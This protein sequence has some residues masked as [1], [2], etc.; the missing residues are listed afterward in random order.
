MPV[1]TA[2]NGSV[3]SLDPSIDGPGRW[4]ASSFSTAV[5]LTIEPI[6]FYDEDLCR[7]RT[8]FNLVVSNDAGAKSSRDAG[9]LGRALVAVSADADYFADVI[10]NVDAAGQGKSMLPPPTYDYGNTA[11]WSTPCNV[12]INAAKD[13]DSIEL[14]TFDGTRVDIGH[15]E[16][17]TFIDMLRS[18][19]EFTGHWKG[20]R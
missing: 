4:Y 18:A 19:R 8:L 9:D 20:D 1:F 14:D 17:D 13:D 16:L 10:A 7:E 2:P 5:T 12:G 3:L 15:T 6:T 11:Q